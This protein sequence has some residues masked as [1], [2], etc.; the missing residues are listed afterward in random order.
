MSTRL[1]N[2]VVDSSAPARLARF[3]AELLGWTV[4]VEPD[5]EVDV[6]A[7]AGDGYDGDLVFVPVP[8]PKVGKNRLHIDLNSTSAEHQA[9]LVEHACDLGAR[10]ADI[11]QGEVPWVVLADPEDNEFCVLEPR[12]LY[13]SAG[14]L[15]AIVLD[16]HDPLTLARFWAAAA[17]WT[18]ASDSPVYT[19]L[20]APHRRGPFLE[21][22]PA[23][24][25]PQEA[26]QM[27]G[28]EHPMRARGRPNASDVDG[29][30]T[31]NRLHL[32]VRPYADGDLEA[33]VARLLE[34]GA[35]PADVGQGDVPWTVLT[36]PEHNE[37]CVLT[38]G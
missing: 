15:A 26:D 16:A 22:L 20:R 17:G 10:R 18:P 33:E 7:P 3:W 12:R 11:G 28:A 29:N 21:F 25:P 1:V 8:E 6:R 27:R 36:D 9:E 31:K 4:A 23:E 13:R 35:R 19:A 32:D 30:R 34:L 5:D 14:A 24:V 38:P 2:I 37:F